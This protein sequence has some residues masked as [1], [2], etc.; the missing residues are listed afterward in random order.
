MLLYSDGNLPMFGNT[1][2][3]N[4]YELYTSPKTFYEKQEKNKQIQSFAKQIRDAPILLKKATE[5]SFQY[6]ISLDSAIKLDAMKMSGYI[7]N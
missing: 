5:K 3:D 4:A 2:I 6:K 1:F 7:K